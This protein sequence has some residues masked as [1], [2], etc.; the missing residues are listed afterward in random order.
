[1][2]TKM[3][4]WTAG[5]TRMNRIR[6]DVIW[7]KFGVAPI[8]EKMREARLRWYGHVL[9][10]KE[11]SV[12]KIGLNFEV[13]SIIIANGECLQS[14]T[15]TMNLV[16]RLLM[17]Y[18]PILYEE[19]LSQIL[20]NQVLPTPENMMMHAIYYWCNEHP[21]KLKL[22]SEDY[23]CIRRAQRLVP[24]EQ[25]NDGE[26]KPS[27]KQYNSEPVSS[28][29]TEEGCVTEE[30][31]NRCKHRH[32]AHVHAPGGGIGKQNVDE[33]TTCPANESDWKR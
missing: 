10:G 30:E 13:S 18:V 32:A 28:T 17:Q 15:I 29:G 24:A 11:D 7:Q 16:K 9:R 2:E 25:T 20:F 33:E 3:L 4:R 1:M 14:H 21:E 5:V 12:R 19:M 6:N 26:R 8:A 23:E 22:S 27:R 31:K